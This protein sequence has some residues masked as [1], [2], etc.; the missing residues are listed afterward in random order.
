MRS[1]EVDV[2]KQ[3]A[4]ASAGTLIGDIVSAV[5]EKGYSVGKPTS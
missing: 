1:V 5:Y 2:A 4:T 3:T